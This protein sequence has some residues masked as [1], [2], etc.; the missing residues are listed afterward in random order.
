MRHLW[1]AI[2]FLAWAAFFAFAALLLALRFWI[3]PD[4]ER[5]R[6]DIV[7]A[8]SRTIGAPVKIG[9]IEAGWLGLRPQVNLIDVRIHDAQ[10]RE[11]LVLPAVENVV[12]WRSLLV[13][14]LRL[15]SLA[16][17]RPRLGVRRDAAGVL[18]V[19]G[20][21]LADDQSDGS[22]ADWILD[23]HEIVVRDADIEWLDEK[24]GAP[25]LALSGLELRLRNTGD[26]HSIGLSARPPAA[27]GT[28]L[29]LRAE[30][31]GRSAL[32]LAAWNG[33]T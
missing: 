27:L 24:R 29:E 26:Q 23:Q 2:E 30:L 19:A 13:G 33:R 14:G 25:P 9:A 18:Y 31:T 16:I 11:A 15:H 8:A 1:R 22:V 32:D 28:G 21:K 17:D 6:D 3:L 4:I 12:A 5:Y 7:A 20:I 10:G